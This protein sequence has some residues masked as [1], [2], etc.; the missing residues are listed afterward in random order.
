MLLGHV[1]VP[2]TLL[3]P[4]AH[5]ASAVKVQL[6]CGPLKEVQLVQEVALPPADH[7]LPAVQLVQEAPIFT[8]PAAHVEQPDAALQLAP[9]HPTQG[10]HAVEE[11]ATGV[12]E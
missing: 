2:L 6:L 11:L 4:P 9:L 7:V 12:V 8:L 5:E 1:H 10:V 3:E